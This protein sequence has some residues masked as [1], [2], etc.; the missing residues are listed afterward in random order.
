MNLFK[1]YKE[2]LTN[3]I[4]HS[5][6]DTISV[7]F[8]IASDGLLL[9]VIDNGVGR[10]EDWGK[11]RGLSNMKKR[12]SEMGGTMTLSSGSGTR[13]SLAI[14]LPLIYPE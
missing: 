5:K 8:R 14:P 12:A 6:A 3:A 13:M 4:K 11:G 7:E 10:E 1:I 2:S 9:N